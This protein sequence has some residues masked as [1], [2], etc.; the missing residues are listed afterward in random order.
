MTDE[1]KKILRIKTKAALAWAKDP[2]RP[3]TH[4]DMTNDEAAAIMLYTVGTA[5]F[6][7]DSLTHSL[8]ITSTHNREL[9]ISQYECRTSCP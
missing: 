2:D 4:H 9:F 3:D 1:D 6:G 7:I 8:T 5:K